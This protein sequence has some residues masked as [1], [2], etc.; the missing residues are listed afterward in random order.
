MHHLALAGQQMNVLINPHLFKSIKLFRDAAVMQSMHEQ[1]SKLNKQGYATDADYDIQTGVHVSEARPRCEH[2][3][4]A[5]YYYWSTLVKTLDRCARRVYTK[6]VGC[7][8]RR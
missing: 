1:K 2:E 8:L 7:G 5:G 6:D 4:S 3:V